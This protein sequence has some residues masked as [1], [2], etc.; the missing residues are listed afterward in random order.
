MP[1]GLCNHFA[2]YNG[3][4]PKTS[5]HMDQSEN[6]VFSWITDEFRLNLIDIAL[7]KFVIPQIMEELSDNL[8]NTRKRR[9]IP[10]F[11]NTAW[12]I[13]N[14]N[15]LTE[16]PETDEGKTFRRRFRVPLD[17]CRILVNVCDTLNVFEIKNKERVI[18]PTA[19]KV[20]ACLR[21]LGRAEVADSLNELCGIGMFVNLRSC[22]C[23]QYA[24]V[25]GQGTPHYLSFSESFVRTSTRDYQRSFYHDQLS[26]N[27]ILLWLITLN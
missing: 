6:G 18:Q 11:A 13:Q 17:I 12:M 20:M 25:Y 21:M 27:L 19:L 22:K 5:Q 4:T 16:D 10:D 8:P 15:E 1:L 2:I 24:Y 23:N 7:E 26:N 3:F 9:A 14:N